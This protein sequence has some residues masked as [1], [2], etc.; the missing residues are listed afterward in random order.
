MFNSP[1]GSRLLATNRKG[2]ILQIRAKK[3][4]WSLNAEG[5]C[6]TVVERREMRLVVEN[7]RQLATGSRLALGNNEGCFG[8]AFR[9]ERGKPS[10]GKSP[11]AL[12]ALG[13]SLAVK[14]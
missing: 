3:K 8:G 5:V 14:G 7:Q 10:K 4:G 2:F 1:V 13:L 11:S 9:C 6:I 12:A